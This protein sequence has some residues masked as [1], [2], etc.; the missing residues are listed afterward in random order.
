M[1]V[2]AELCALTFRQVPE[3][4]GPLAVIYLARTN[5]RSWVKRQFAPPTIRGILDVELTSPDMTV[6]V[7]DRSLVLLCYKRRT[8][9]AAS[10]A[11]THKQ[12]SGNRSTQAK[13]ASRNRRGLMAMH[14]SQ[15][16]AGGSLR[17]G[18]AL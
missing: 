12:G 4:S 2:L 15:P 5:C 13:P 6:P 10:A 7:T 3:W 1:A 14:R 8:F 11:R 17:V 18:Q 16:R 9:S